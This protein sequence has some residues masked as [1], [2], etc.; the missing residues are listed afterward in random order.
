MVNLV[1]MMAVIAQVDGSMPAIVGQSL[2]LGTRPLR[3]A[4][5]AVRYVQVEQD[6]TAAQQFVITAQRPDSGAA[7]KAGDTVVVEFNC[8][9]LLRY[10]EEWAIPLLGDFSHNIRYHKATKK[11]EPIVL[12]Q[13][14]YPT[15]L[16]GTG[17]FGQAQADLLI[18]YDGS[19]IAVRVTE[20]SGSAEAD[21]AACDAGLQASFSPGENYGAPCRVWM[22]VPYS[23]EHVE[24]E[25]LKSSKPDQTYDEGRSKY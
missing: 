4:G 21:S 16:R 18:D 12:P 15:K 20:S 14:D 24:T 8:V 5:L 1:L 17:F 13:A 3:K 11:P 10:W 22:A 25:E 7:L 23:W 6:T 2:F 9:G 19:V